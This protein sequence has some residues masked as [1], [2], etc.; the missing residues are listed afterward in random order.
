MTTRSYTQSELLD[1]FIEAYQSEG[2]ARGAFHYLLGRLLI[3]DQ[4]HAR[5]EGVPA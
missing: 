4:F 1:I 5:T 2:D 3:A